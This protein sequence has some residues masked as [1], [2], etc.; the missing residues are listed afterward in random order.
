MIHRVWGG[1]IGVLSQLGGTVQGRAAVDALLPGADLPP[2]DE[3]HDDPEDHEGS[4]DT[5]NRG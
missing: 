5:T 2:V 3:E 1:G 4:G